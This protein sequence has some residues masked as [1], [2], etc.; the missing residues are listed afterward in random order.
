MKRFLVLAA[1]AAVVAGFA[2]SSTN[3]AVT[4][5]ESPERGYVTINGSANK[6]L[7]PDLAEISISVVTSD[8]KSMQNATLENKE[9][10]GKVYT[11]LKEMINT[12][13]G[14]YVKTSNFR[15]NPIY[16]YSSNGKK[17]LSKYEV[18]NTVTVHTKSIDKVGDMIDKA[19]SLGATD[20][21]NLGF[22]LSKYEQECDALLAT[23]TQRARTQADSMVKAAGSSITGIKTISGSC[24]PNTPSRVTYRNMMLS[25][26][27]ADSVA[28]E[29]ASYGESVPVQAGAVKIYANVNASFFVK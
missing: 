24:T 17:N 2:V 6:E 11:A 3:A 28:S 15:A 10:S 4:V 13:N 26:K 7:T 16:T 22:T 12:E 9:I 25:A 5:T 18:S 27:A 19:I 29:G 14:D 8:N 1:A 23:A 20:V 21:S